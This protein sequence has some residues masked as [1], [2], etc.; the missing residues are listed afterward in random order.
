MAETQEGAGGGSVMDMMAMMM[1]QMIKEMKA[2]D[3][4][5]MMGQ[6]MPGMMEQCFASMSP[7]AMSTMMHEMMPRMMEGCFSKMDAEQRRGMLTMCRQMLDQM[8]AK[9]L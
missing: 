4:M 1:P 5:A 3:M 7:E 8:E 2:E 6:M 9:Y